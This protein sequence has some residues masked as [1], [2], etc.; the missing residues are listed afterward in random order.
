[1]G[2]EADFLI[3]VTIAMTH[4]QMRALACLAFVLAAAIPSSAQTEGKIAVGG[5]VGTRIAPG[6]NVGGD[7]FGI[8][9]LWRI[10]HSKP[11]FGWEWGLNWLTSD[12]DRSIGG[13]VADLG[14]LHVRPIMVGYGY[15]HL[16][17]TNAI[18][19]SVQGGYAFTSFSPDP[20]AGPLYLVRLGATSFSTDASN[21]FV[22]RPQVSVWRDMSPKVG[23]N[24][25]AGYMI[26]RPKLTIR[27]SLGEDVERLNADMFM[28]KVGLV[29]SV[30]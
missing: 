28:L 23:L 24:I 13:V 22:V 10:G 6:A 29:Y 17:G 12:V 8:S 3:G 27:T 1:V 25:T 2:G 18:K 4:R 11:G 30:F 14:D 7:H 26:A 9:L 5:S 21:T 20:L 15:T 19:G 16:I